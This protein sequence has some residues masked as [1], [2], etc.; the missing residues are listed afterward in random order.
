[1]S[2]KIQVSLKL[3]NLKVAYENH[4]A[5]ELPSLELTGNVVAI[6]GH[7]GAGKSTLIKTLLGLLPPQQGSAQVHLVGNGA[8]TTHDHMAFCPETGAVFADISVESYIK[9]WCRLKHNNARYYLQRGKRIIDTLC[10]SPLFKKLGRE[11]SK[12][13]KRRVQ[14]AIGFLCEPL[15][16]LFDEPFDGLDVQKT[17]ELTNLLIDN[18]DKMAFAVS[19]HRMDVIER[20]SDVFIVLKEGQIAAIGSHAEVCEILASHSVVVSELKNF[21]AAALVLR[22]RLP[23][24]VVSRVGTQLIISGFE[25]DPRAISELL[26]TLGE[27]AA[28]CEKIPVSLV[29]AMNYHLKELDAETM[30]RSA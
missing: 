1:M 10:I 14:T 29:E 27:G 24:L 6:L 12:G 9:L 2:D 18:C 28:H 19:S 20:I 5:L 3:D 16:F 8:L 23:K 11:L 21:D 15:F 4:V 17:N 13:Q 30:R 26:Q 25:A 22:Q 7:N